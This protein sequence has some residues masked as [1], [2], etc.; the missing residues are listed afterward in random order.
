MY[1]HLEMG[2]EMAITVTLMGLQIASILSLLGRSLIQTSF[3]IILKNVAHTW[4]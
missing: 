1:L 2:V 4:L 3:L